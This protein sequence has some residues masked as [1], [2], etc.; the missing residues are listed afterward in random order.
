MLSEDVV[1][2]GVLQSLHILECE[3]KLYKTLLGDE[4][5]ADVFESDRCLTENGVVRVGSVVRDGDVL[6]GKFTPSRD[7]HN[8]LVYTDSCYKLP[9]GTGSA[10]VV[11]I[12]FSADVSGIQA[13]DLNY[14]TA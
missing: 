9:V 11:S 4:I 2:R 1:A 13:S 5:L 6:V 3:V 10:T 12:Q 7:S 14:C 8:Q